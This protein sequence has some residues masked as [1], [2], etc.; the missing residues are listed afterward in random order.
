MSYRNPHP[1][2]CHFYA[3]VPTTG[4]ALEANVMNGSADSRIIL[5]VYSERIEVNEMRML[6]LMCG[7]TRKGKM[8]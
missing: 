4:L 8:E 5:I 7:V 6:R 3:T 2:C 1:R